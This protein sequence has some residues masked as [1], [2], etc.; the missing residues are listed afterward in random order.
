MAL[1]KYGEFMVLQSGKTGGTINSKGKGGAYTK[2]FVIPT[3]PR[4]SYQIAARNLQTSFAQNWRNLTQVQR[5]A[6]NAAATAFPYVNR[7]GDS[8]ILS[9]IALYNKLNVNLTNAG[10]AAITVPPVP[11]GVIAVIS[12]VP[13]V[14]A[15][16]T[17]V[18]YT[19]TPVPAGTSFLVWAT[20]GISPGI[21]YVTNRFRL[22]T[23]IAAA[24]VSPLIVTGFYNARFGVAPVGSRVFFGL[25]PINAVTGEAGIML[26][27]STIAI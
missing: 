14:I 20:P 22:I 27:A 8:K 26:V 18:A 6:W 24:G 12:V 9:G 19:P 25:Q 21:K 16:V 5:D 17:T 7:V 1:V 11:S 4:T 10:T 2:N 23:K 15:G 13:T 3:N